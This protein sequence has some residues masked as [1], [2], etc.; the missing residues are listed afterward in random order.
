MF[1]EAIRDGLIYL[2]FLFGMPLAL[3][4]AFDLINMC[5]RLIGRSDR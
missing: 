2:A 1:L 5:I 3:G 4:I